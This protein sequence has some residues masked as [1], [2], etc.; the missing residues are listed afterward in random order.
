VAFIS[1]CKHGE[2]LRPFHVQNVVLSVLVIAV[3]LLLM[4]QVLELKVLQRIS[5]AVL[6][7]QE[8]E[9]QPI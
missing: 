5:R 9:M 2:V 8:Q 6:V 3:L 7:L 4:E 1:I